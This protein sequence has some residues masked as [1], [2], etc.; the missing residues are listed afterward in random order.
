MST[1]LERRKAEA[2]DEMCEQMDALAAEK[3][4]L[5]ALLNAAR[6]LL[7]DMAAC[8]SNTPTLAR[9][10]ALIDELGEEAGA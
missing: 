6:N 7:I 8:M 1:L 5:K 3:R 4:R 2:Y 9:V 10:E